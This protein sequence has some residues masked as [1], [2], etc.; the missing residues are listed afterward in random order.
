MDKNQTY[1]IN[2]L[3]AS[4]NDKKIEIDN[5]E[6]INWEV[7]F[8]EA[9]NHKI[10]SL[11]YS[12]IHNNTIKDINPILLNKI[13]HDVFLSNITQ[14]KNYNKLIKIISDLKK[15]DIEVIVLKGIVLR[16]YY[17]RPE[18]RTMSD[19]DILAKSKDYAHI[20]KYLLNNGFKYNN[21]NSEVHEGFIS[22]E[23]LIIEVH[24]KLI[25]N[26]VIRNNI[27]EYE[28]SLWDNSIKIKIDKINTN[29]LSMEDFV[30]HLCFHMETHAIAG[31]GFGLRQI[32]DLAIFLK[33]N[34]KDIRWEYLYKKMHKYNIIYFSELLFNVIHTI[35]D[36]EINELFLRD[37]RIT[38]QNI[39]SFLE[40]IFSCGVYG[41]KKENII[42]K[43]MNKKLYKKY[44]SC[45]LPN[46]NYMS[47]IY[48]YVNKNI[49]LLPIAWIHRILRFLFRR[50]NIKCK[51]ARII[52]CL[53]NGY[54]G[55]RII[56]N[57]KHVK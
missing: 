1:M 37:Y 28:Q 55:M 53:N 3:K 46:R 48:P 9:R 25:N 17:K 23:N 14:I 45:M 29:T 12:S 18:L 30:I 6:D 34:Y 2:I 51:I 7:I 20:K 16:Q 33:K 54:N 38:K 40:K 39:N 50:E 8:E 24:S 49:L 4:I 47:I 35:F 56:D 57:F 5:K 44:I 31:G 22:G 13:K 10:T 43:D 26:N 42:T 36:V 19:Y 11:I 27:K 52:Y 21:H 32:Y 15:Q 41:R